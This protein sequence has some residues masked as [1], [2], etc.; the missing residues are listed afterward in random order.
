MPDMTFEYP[1][2]PD[3]VTWVRSSFSQEA[4]DGVVE[5]AFLADGG[6]ALRTSTSAAEGVPPLYYTPAEWDAFLAGVR[7][8][9]F[10]EP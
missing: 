1:P 10:D 5:I 2:I 7:A 9:E 6:V 3:D 8:G 4:D